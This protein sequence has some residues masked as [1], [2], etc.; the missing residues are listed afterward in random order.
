MKEF[1]K[2]G[3]SGVRG[4]VGASFTPQVAVAFARAFASFLGQGSVLVGRDTRPS[5]FA[6]ECAVVAGLQSSGCKPVLAGI[7]PTPTI[8]MLV[9]LLGARGGIAITASHNPPQ[10]NALK[11]VGPNGLF[12]SPQRANELF[13][14]YHQ[15]EFA[16]VGEDGLPPVTTLEAP[17]EE[18]FNKIMQYVDASA[19]RARKFRVAVDCCNGVGA[20]YTRA[21]LERLGCEVF[22][23][24]DTPTGA[25]EREPEPL[26]ENLGTLGALVRE[27]K[28]HVG[29]AQDPDGDRLAI[30]NEQGEPIGEDLTV[31]FAV[32]QVL[33]CHGKGP[34]AI[35]LSTSR[36]VAWVAEQRSCPV[37]R[38]KIGE[39]NV[40]QALLAAGAVVGGEGNGG[41][42]V[43][44]I[45]PCRDSFTGMAL[46]LELMAV[47]GKTVSE[48]RAAIPRHYLVKD[49]V[50][51]RGER[52]TSILRVVRRK[53]EHLKINLQDGVY[54][55][56]DD[57]WFHVRASNTEPV[58][59][60][61]AE[62][63]NPETARQ[64]AQTV[65]AEILAYLAKEPGSF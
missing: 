15:G 19:V 1:L 22:T 43:P 42:V 63:R 35:H 50:P 16:L 8:C 60:I 48:L 25:F 12:L 49:K 37:I 6:T 5:G 33:D 18:H 29:F 20:L 58:I 26:P 31:A 27:H 62:A 45:H 24:F 13:D 7:V 56:I 59:R 3:I 32:Q 2:V 36:S 10:W 46:V 39:I 47:T 11:F 23:C 61:S 40:V 65:R 52:V 21:F 54:V 30:V 53:Y 64:I 9:P 14:I 57:G 51:V 41:V 28:C 17:A 4:V 44:A 55:E 34:V 38:S